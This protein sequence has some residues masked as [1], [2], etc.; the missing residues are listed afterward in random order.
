MEETPISLLERLRRPEDQDAWV[1]FVGLTAPFLF[2][3]ACRFGLQDAD[4]ADVTQDVL[5]QLSQQLPT[6]R[7]DPNR[8]FRS[9]LR[10]ILLNRCRDHL[11][12]LAEAVVQAPGGLPLPDVAGHDS[13][14][15]FADEE[16]RRA[17]AVRALQFIQI[18]FPESAWK[19]CWEQVVHDRPAAEVA[20]E[21]GITVNMAYLARSRVLARLRQELAGLWE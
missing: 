6:F 7:Y 9:W 15:I 8:R 5:T 13:A 16:F 12:R 1:R 21:L 2:S 18:E 14:Q 11:R 10:T 4:A 19:A 3:V 17:V 20:Q